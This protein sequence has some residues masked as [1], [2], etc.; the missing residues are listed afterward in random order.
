M[1]YSYKQEN[2]ADTLIRAMEQGASY[3]EVDYLLKQRNRKIENGGEAMAQYKNDDLTKDAQAYLERK[4]TKPRLDLDAFRAAREETAAENLRLA[5]K[6]SLHDY[7]SGINAIDRDA[8]K[9]RETLYADYR[10]D[11]LVGDE[12]L[13]ANGL[14]KAHGKPSSGYGET[15]KTAMYLGYQN[16]LG[17]IDE[18]ADEQKADLYA[19]YQDRRDADRQTYAAARDAIAKETAQQSI[20][21]FNDDREFLLD[22]SKHNVENN[23][24]N[25]EFDYAQKE[26]AAKRAHDKEMFALESAENR[27]EAVREA[28]AKRFDNALNAFKATGVINTQEMA[29]ALGLPMGTKTLS[30]EDFENQ[31]TYMW[32]EYNR[33]LEWHEEE[34]R[35]KEAAAAKKA[36]SSG[37]SKGK[38]F[39]DYYNLFKAVGEVITKEMAN[40]LGLPMGTKYWQYVESQKESD[41]KDKETKFEIGEW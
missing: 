13:A 39:D 24:W 8:Q 1:S 32:S 21:Q 33:D 29:D 10:R 27:E 19:D 6:R 37:G 40:A 41:R 18:K 16:A 9:K 34:M 25:Q 20:D 22:E 38:D 28:Q 15:A 14:G 2:I 11:T 31:S 12:A 23:H 3:D 17:Q 26:D 30:R 35:A 36:A 5:D 4:I 7:Q